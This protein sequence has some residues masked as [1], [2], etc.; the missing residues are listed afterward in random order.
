MRFASTVSLKTICLLTLTFLYLDLCSMVK[1]KLLDIKRRNKRSKKIMGFRK[2]K[3]QHYKGNFYEVL[4]LVLHSETEERL[5]LYKPLY[6][7]SHIQT[8][9]SDSTGYSPNLWVR[10]FDMFFEEIQIAGKRVARFAYVG[11]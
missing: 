4:D 1:G 10:P 11:D 3:Y 6:D 7:S 5:V 2:G 9:S 8:D